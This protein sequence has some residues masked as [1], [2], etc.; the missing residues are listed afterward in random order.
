MLATK[1]QKFKLMCV[2]NCLEL[3]CVQITAFSS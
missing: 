1:T 3:H 2:R